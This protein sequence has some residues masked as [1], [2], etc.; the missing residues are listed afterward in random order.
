[1]EKSG[2]SHAT[3]R[4]KIFLFVKLFVLSYHGFTLDVCYLLISFYPRRSRYSRLCIVAT[5][6]ANFE[7]EM[8]R[9]RANMP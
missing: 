1:M 6:G 4:T 8:N 5:D 2:T 7:N 9:A 3:R